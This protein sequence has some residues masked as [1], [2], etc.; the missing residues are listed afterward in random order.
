[1]ALPYL[2]KS[3]DTY[4]RAYWTMLDI[5]LK[6]EWKIDI[7]TKQK[8]FL[9][10]EYIHPR[11]SKDTLEEI[12]QEWGNCQHDAIGGFLWGV[13]EGI[14]RGKNIIRNEKD[15]QLIQKLVWYLATCEYW[16]DPDNGV[17][18][19]WREVHSSSVGACVAGLTAV[20][21]IVF[22]PR[23]LIL[24][25]WQTLGL[26]YAH[27]SASRPIDLAQLTLIYPFKIYQGEDAKD[28]VAEVENKLLRNR[29]VIRYQGDSY[30]STIED[31]G[32]S[33]ALTHYHGTEMEWCMGIS[34]LGLAHLEIGNVEK[35][36]MYRDWSRSLA[37]E[38]GSIPEGYFANTNRPNPNTPLGWSN[39]MHILLEERLNV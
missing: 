34:W 1:M 6:Y 28:V 3:C 22:V 13:G 14:K 25:G 31:E 36:K 30:Y 5:F 35:A 7:H 11:Y 16:I 38:D 17:W 19:E 18:E 32:R 15:R 39:A 33:Q 21:E 27:E 9:I 4:E 29:G 37:L 26:M 20:R 12:N 2:D 23:D 24:K 10:Y 8:P